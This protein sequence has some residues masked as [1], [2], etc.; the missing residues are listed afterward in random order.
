MEDRRGFLK[1]LGK[2]AAAV[3]ITTTSAACFQKL[4]DHGGHKHPLK[5]KN[6][7]TPSGGKPIIEDLTYKTASITRPKDPVVFASNSHV[8]PTREIAK[9]KAGFTWQSATNL[10]HSE[11]FIQPASHY[12]NAESNALAQEHLNSFYNAH[13]DNMS[14]E[15]NPP[16]MVVSAEHYA[17]IMK[18]EQKRHLDPYKWG[19]V[20]DL[21]WI[22][23]KSKPNMDAY[24]G[25][26]EARVKRAFNKCFES[27]GSNEIFRVNVII[28]RHEMK[29]AMKQSDHESNRRLIGIY[30]ENAYRKIVDELQR[31]IRQ[32]AGPEQIFA[33]IADDPSIRNLREINGITD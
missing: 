11:S 3:G 30:K 32:E 8:Q 17:R 7:T 14:M 16:Q 26:W 24:E 25:Y 33:E 10:E 19:E 9:L 2:L 22:P 23:F 20:F 6:G 29:F 27:A 1:T 12:R 4:H 13:L 5:A 21:K 15:L 31:V 28:S 18:L